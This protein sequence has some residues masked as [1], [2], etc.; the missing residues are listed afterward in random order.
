MK[1]KSLLWLPV[2]LVVGCGDAALEAG[3]ATTVAQALSGN[4]HPGKIQIDGGAA[5]AD[6]F[7]TAGTA[8]NTPANLDWVADQASNS[9]TNCIQ[10]DGTATCIEPGVTG[11]LG[12]VGH[13]NGIR[14]VDGIA[15]NDRDIFLTGGKENDTST[16]NPGPGSVGSAK[17]DIGQAY[18]ANN[19]TEVYFG[20]E[21]RGNNGS[22]AFDFEFNQFP[23]RSRPE[24]PNN[25]I[26]PCRTVGDVLFTF[27]M[28]GSGSTGSAVPHVYRYDG[29]NYVERS[30]A[31]IVSSINN[32]A[33][34]AGPPWGHVTGKGDWALGSLDRFTFAEA[35]APIYLLPTV[36]GC[37][38]NAFVQVRTRSS[39]VATSDL[40]DLTQVFEFRF[41]SITPQATLAPTCGEAFT[42]D[43]SA[44]ATNNVLIEN[45]TCHWVFSNGA[46]SDSCAGTL[47][48]SAGAHS[49]TLTITDPTNTVCPATATSN[50]V[51]VYKPLSVTPALTGTCEGAFDYAATV[52][53]GSDPAQV[54]YEWS[55][56][57]GTPSSSTAAS[58]T[59]GVG[60]GG[61]F[62]GSVVVTDSRT[63]ITCTSSGSAG[64]DVSMPLQVQLNLETVV[65]S[66]PTLSS[67]AVTY[68]AAASGGDGN[69]TFTWAGPTCT[70]SS[71]TVDPEDATLCDSQ[72]VSVTV[73]D[74]SGCAPA[75]SET[76]TYE[77]V[78]TITA[79]DG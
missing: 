71:C 34:T 55:F 36:N 64:T 38:G 60:A 44:R 78:T 7:A 68:Q 28:Q 1:A 72:T 42:F 30:S 16:W 14:I 31:G 76:E 9:G 27:E 45:P 74:T 15:S 26:V 59:V 75:T 77:K 6:L 37:G 20:M 18:L 79:T 13:P 29:T 8:I 10:A 51:N 40:K 66:C 21:R 50:T 19:Q 25:P 49:G 39:A 12:G 2:G 70:G 69:Y 24:C 73:S 17:Y 67:D 32:A 46:T 61:S 3:D 54:S 56:S 48:A 35:V 43:A 53:G 33:N 62:T 4:I 41:N 11:A 23:P 47:P 63:D 52:S 5:G 65:D 58:G 57:S 22:T